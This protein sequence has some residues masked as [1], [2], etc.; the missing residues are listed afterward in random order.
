MLPGSLTPTIERQRFEVRDQARYRPKGYHDGRDPGCV[1]EL[2]RL[3][4][5]GYAQL[6]AWR[7]KSIKQVTNNTITP[8]YH[9]LRWTVSGHLIRG[10]LRVKRGGHPRKRMRVALTRQEH[11]AQLSWRERLRLSH[12]N[13]GVVE[14]PDVIWYY[15]PTTARGRAQHFVNLSADP[16]ASRILA[17]A[18]HGGRLDDVAISTHLFDYLLRLGLPHTT[19]YER[20]VCAVGPLLVKMHEKEETADIVAVS[21][22]PLRWYY[23]PGLTD[24][25]QQA[26]QQLREQGLPAPAAVAAAQLLFAE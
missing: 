7:W 11:L 6:E 8:G 21:Y 9:R 12:T 5:E 24:D 2:Q 10:G 15:A 16:V 14:G 26:Y 18:T 20:P 1:V 17:A 4:A 23:A 25:E 19:S 22:L 13:L 3:D